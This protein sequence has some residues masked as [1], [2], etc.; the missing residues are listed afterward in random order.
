MFKYF[1]DNYKLTLLITL[2]IVVA[3]LLNLFSM[4][5]E[6]F[7]NVDFAQAV[8]TTYYPG[9]TPEDVELLITTKIEDAVRQIAGIK[10][11]TSVSQA[12]LSEVR[13][14]VDLDNVDTKSTLTDIQRAVDRVTDLPE[15]LPQSPVFIE[16]KTDQIPVL[17]LAI[18]SEK[19]VE[20]QI[21]RDNADA[22]QSTLELVP[23]V[24]SVSKVGYLD[25]E[26]RVLLDPKKMSDQH[27]SFNEVIRAVQQNNVNSPGGVLESSPL[28]QSMLIDSKLDDAKAIEKTVVRTNLSKQQVR[29]EDIGEVN[30]QF[31]RPSVIAKTNG[32]P[33]IVLVVRKAGAADIVNLTKD[34]K[35]KIT[36]FSQ[37]MPSELSVVITDDEST[38][39][40][41]RLEIVVS[42]SIL[43]FV[44]LFAATVIFLSLRTSIVT[45]MSVP[46]IILFTLV[47][48]SSLGITFNVIS[49]LAIVIALGMFVDNS[50]VISENIY[51]LT[52]LGM[53][54]KQAAVQGTKE[55]ATPIVATVLTTIAAF[56]PLSVTSGILGQ[57]IWSIPVIVSSS[58]IISLF[59]SFFLLPAR[60][61][62]LSKNQVSRDLGWFA[63]LQDKF[64][65]LM[66]HLLQHK[67][68]TTA[69]LF[70]LLI[71]SFI[72]ANSRLSFVL[73]PPEGVDKFVVRYSAPSG[74]AIEELHQ[75][76]SRVEEKLVSLPKSEFMSVTTR[77]GI[78]NEGPGDPLARKGNN[79]GMMI[80][81]LT[82]E[83]QRNRTAAEIINQLRAEI[84]VYSPLDK[85]SFATIANGPP[86]GKAVTVSIKGTNL[87][88]LK[89]IAKDMQDYLGT[90]KGVEDIASDLQVGLRQLKVRVRA[91][92]AA[93]Y[94]ISAGSIAYAIRTALEGSVASTVRE[95]ADDMD[96]RVMLKDEARSD[97]EVLS[98]ILISNPLGNLIPLSK[99]ASIYESEPDVDRKHFNHQRSITVT[100]SV[101]LEFITSGMVNQLLVE[102]YQD[103][104][105]Q[106]P[107]YS[108][109]FSGEEESSNESMESLGRA[110]I[111]AILGIFTI[112]VATL[113]SYFKPLLIILSIP[114]SFIGPIMGFLLHGKSF[115]FI[116]MIGIIGLTGVV[117]N[118]AIIL[119]AVIDNIR[120]NSKLSL[121][122]CLV[123]GSVVRLR[124]IVLTTLT[125]ILAL[126]PTAYGIGG[127]DPILVPMTLAMAWGLLFGTVITL[128]IVPCGYAILEDFSPQRAADTVLE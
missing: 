5:R 122:E 66:S 4:K 83:N 96:I 54:V 70:A 65:W 18:V 67:Y 127:Y 111:L 30:K 28:E 13:V 20:Y 74:T 82:N 25:R 38:R 72:I 89:T 100:A 101:D 68:K 86:V 37:I 27:V 24:A 93:N 35:T 125:T 29:V 116:A 77:T 103:L 1:V 61:V 73:F 124:P 2:V 63:V 88:T 123:Q 23:G 7:P 22:L 26:L 109:K 114:F 91:D 104:P 120:S 81:S 97:L 33:S 113:K 64:A 34:L 108:L 44:L 12:G 94:G 3:G 105:K 21:M 53:P 60:V 98:S 6:A 31:A 115:G 19:A 112:L 87:E 40:M 47:I 52:Q 55:I 118:A 95:F 56:M 50:I 69:G 106:Y 80:V 16:I 17:E 45:S 57:F 42:N 43:G 36:E 99:V 92:A 128:I 117:I 79:V 102:H 62:L 8:I 110:M 78:Q 49:M 15:D 119:V 9:A 39:T 58:L 76:V 41:N 14:I 10:K 32:K 126:I 46:I 71:G 48:M 75:A 51:R 11:V 121:H 107:G 59:E 90:I 85:L 84:P